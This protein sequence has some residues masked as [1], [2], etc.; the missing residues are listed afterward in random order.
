MVLTEIRDGDSTANGRNKKR[1]E[2]ASHSTGASTALVTTVC[3]WF[4]SN[5]AASCDTTT[6]S[7][8]VSPRRLRG[9]YSNWS[10]VT[11]RTGTGSMCLASSPRE[12]PGAGR[13]EADEQVRHR[14]VA[15]IAGQAE[16]RGDCQRALHPI[17]TA[18]LAVGDPRI[19]IRSMTTRPRAFATS[20]GFPSRSRGT[21]FR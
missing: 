18:V 7:T 16:G 13:P 4:G 2:R 12:R 19:S 10:A 17:P 14:R 3:L 1:P 8:A 11:C 9:S 5:R 20:G 21:R 6:W 15:D